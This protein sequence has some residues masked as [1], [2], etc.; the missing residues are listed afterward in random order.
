MPYKWHISHDTDWRLAL[1]PHRSLPPQGFV[2]FIAITASFLLIPLL[3]VLGSPVL[4]VLLPF[5]VGALWLVWYFLRRNTADGELREDLVLKD[6]QITLTRRNPRRPDQTW[7]ADP[8]RVRVDLHASGGPVANYITLS[9]GAREV[10]IG[11]F[12]SP[13]ER[14]VLFAELTDRLRALDINAPH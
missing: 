3:A 1:W 10:E 6:G 5:L 2:I 9:G 7:Q 8:Y 14:A 4:W 11:A 13:D 12:L